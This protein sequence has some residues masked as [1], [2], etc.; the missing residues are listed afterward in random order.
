M[1][2]ARAAAAAVAESPPGGTEPRPRLGGAAGEM[3]EGRERKPGLV[4]GIMIACHS[5]TAEPQ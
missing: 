3:K 1:A 2:A 5:G 4:Y